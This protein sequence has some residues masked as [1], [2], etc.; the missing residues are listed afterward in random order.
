ML[1]KKFKNQRD[2]I[3]ELTLLPNN[4]LEG[5]FTTAVASKECQ[6]IIGQRQLITG[7]WTGNTLTFSVVYEQCG[8]IYS[9]VGNFDQEKNHIDVIGLINHQSD[10]ATGKDCGSR[11]ITHDTYNSIN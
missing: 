9:V 1:S 3:L 10:D 11:Y 8:S 5:Y 6:Q 2:S 7:L 4:Q